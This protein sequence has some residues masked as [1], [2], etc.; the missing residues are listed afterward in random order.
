MDLL[1]LIC[2]LG[3]VAAFALAFGGE[4]AWPLWLRRTLLFLAGLGAVVAAGRFAYFVAGWLPAD[5]T[6]NSYDFKVFYDAA[7]VA[8]EWGP[9]YDVA[10]IRGDPGTIV[11][12]RH[13][14][15]GAGLFVPWTL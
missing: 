1:L 5:S 11:V 15:I 8:R 2:C 6:A 14:P 9:L 4:G 13:T 10:S 12:Y 7:L 3:A